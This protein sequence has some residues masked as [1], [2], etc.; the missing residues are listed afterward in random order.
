MTVGRLP[1][2]VSAVGALILLTPGA[3]EKAIALERMEVRRDIGEPEWRGTG[4]I[5]I[6]YF[7][8]CTDWVWEW[9]LSVNDRSGVAFGPAGTGCR[10]SATELYFLHGASPGYGYTGLLEV[11]AADDNSCPTGAPLASAPFLPHGGWNTVQWGDGSGLAVPSSFVVVMT[12]LSAYYPCVGYSLT[13]DHPAPGGTSP[14]ACGTCYPAPRTVHSFAYGPASSPLC[15]GAPS[16]DW[17]C[18]VEFLWR[19]N[20]GCA[21]S[22]EEFPIRTSSWARIKSVYR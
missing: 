1:W 2:L 19:A 17:V 20:V 18:D 4:T 14:P 7:N 16:N 3:S 6:Q 21:T 8:T 11:Y 9:G 15:P 13:S 5:T 22:A 10:L 12:H